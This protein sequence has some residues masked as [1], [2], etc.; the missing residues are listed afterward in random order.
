MDLDHKPPIAQALTVLGLE[1]SCDETAAAL[2]R[3]HVDGRVE[4]LSD[5]ITDQ[6]EAHTPYGGVVPEI[7]ARQ[8]ADIM[9][10]VVAQT[11]REANLSYGELDGVA[12]TCG[13][14]LIGGVLVGMMTGKAIA[15]AANLPFIAI[16]HLEGHALSPRLGASLPFPYLLLLVS[17][18]H[19][20]LLAIEGL[21]QYHRYGSTLDDAVGEAFD[22]AAK[23]MGLGFPG[24][25]AVEKIAKSGNAKRFELPRPLAKRSG[26]DFSYSGLKSAVQRIWQGLDNPS[27][28][29]KADLAASFQLAATDILVRQTKKALVRFAEQFANTHLVVAGGVAANALVRA[30]L[31]TLANT[32]GFAFLAPPLRYCT[33]NGAMIA[34]A[35]AEHL[36][37]GQTSALDVAARPRWPLDE[38][39]ANQN[40]ASGSGKKGPKS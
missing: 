26:C 38:A 8:H 40:P 2:V 31:E 15:L 37:R 28:Q 10:Q 13:P 34:L 24:G 30:Q 17:G 23:I 22:K 27:S 4:I 35:G 21:G 19:T 36:A 29:D 25:P 20:Q 14:G 18:G 39:A 16:N 32:H 11:M 6:I 12:A 1:S 9:D 7:A 3:L 5:C 33:D